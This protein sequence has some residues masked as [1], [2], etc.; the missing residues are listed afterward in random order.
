MA[1]YQG[2]VNPNKPPD[3]L[4][5][6][7]LGRSS[8]PEQT[9]AQIWASLGNVVHSWLTPGHAIACLWLRSEEER[10]A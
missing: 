3:L 10:I 9:V 4:T 5:G 1:I 6:P 7:S 8:P 2:S